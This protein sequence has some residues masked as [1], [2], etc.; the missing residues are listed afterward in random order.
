MDEWIVESKMVSGS[1]T[2]VDLN[3]YNSANFDY[4][5]KS[6]TNMR[7][8]NIASVWNGSISS[9]NEINTTDLGDTNDLN[10]DVSS[11]GKLNAIVSSG[12]WTVQINYKAL[13]K[14]S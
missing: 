5:I 9:H 6:G 2:L 8:G 1:V 4:M 11:D 12:T 10:F 3:S 7:A 13:G 14:I